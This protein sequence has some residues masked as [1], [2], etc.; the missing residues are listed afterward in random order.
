MRAVLA[1][2]LSITS[3]LPTRS[4][5]QETPLRA[6]REERTSIGGQWFLNYRGGEAGGED[7]S[8]F[9]VDRG[10][11]VIVHRLTDRLSGRIT[12]DVSVD[13]EG[14]GEGDL[15]VRLKY[16][17]VD[18]AFDDIWILTQPHVEFGLVHRSWLDFEEHVNYY[19]VQGTMFIER[20]H[21]FN[22]AD[23]GFTL[24][25][26]LG[27]Q[28]DEEYRERVNSRYPGRYGSMAIGVYNG[29]GYHAIEKNTNKSL[30]ARLTLRPLPDVLPGL[31]F[32]YQGVYGKGN[33]EG[34]PDWTVNLI[35]ASWESPH[36][37]LTGQY[38]WGRG[39]MRGT[40]VDDDGNA[41]PQNG[42][43]LFAEVRS[44]RN[45]LSLTG[46][47]DLFDDTPDISDD[48]KTRFIV[49]LAY[50]VA[51]N[52]KLLLDYDA[53]KRRGIDSYESRLLKFS[54][55]FAF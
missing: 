19:R 18:Y 8:R 46:R 13:R 25:S 50:Y 48:E 26:M 49:G 5:A 10:Y 38:Y 39:N 41:L 30:E 12:P 22:S 54:V 16:A 37:V 32:S 35:F 24:F 23:Y 4:A 44:R 33:D 21:I 43:S 6:E 15:K 52:S 20:N 11:I 9:G 2:A 55:E 28:M 1:I 3:L 53:E 47:L 36:L 14:D 31:Q 17:F 45:G 34:K 27:G 7:V 40:A 29:G 51:G 42:G